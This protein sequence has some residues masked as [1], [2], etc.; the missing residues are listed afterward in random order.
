MTLLKRIPAINGVIKRRL[1]VNFRAEPSV[2]QRLLPGP[3]RPK[4]HAGHAIAGI[5]LIRLERIRPAGLPGLIGLSSENAAHRIAV[6]WTDPAGIEREGV[7][8]PRRDTDST[9]NQLAGGRLFPG[10]HSPARFNVVDVGGRVELS[11]RSLDGAVRVEVAGN[12]SDQL[13]A[14][15]CFDSLAEVSG[16]FERGSLGY[17]ATRNSNRLD[18]LVL[19]TLQWRVRALAVTKVFSSYFSDENRFP[20]GTVEFDHALVM[21]DIPHQWRT[22][23]DLH[24]R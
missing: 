20:K 7:F 16:F 6:E 10:E 13:P 8:I 2:V 4:L 15:S 24:A 5:C 19:H 9:L 17:S 22:A 21:R 12:D 18:G 3:F 23:E 11:M 14:S 1:L